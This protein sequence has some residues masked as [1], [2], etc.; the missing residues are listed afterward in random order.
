MKKRTIKNAD[1]NT[2]TKT[3]VYFVP[4]K[5]S[6]MFI[7]PDGEVVG[8]DVVEN[9]DEVIRALNTFAADEGALDG[10]KFE[11]SVN[12]SADNVSADLAQAVKT[13]LPISTQTNKESMLA[14]NNKLRF[15]LDFRKNK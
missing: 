14:Y 9:E 2:N 15:S 4:I 3:L 12:D 6:M 7:S 13:Y 8:E 1:K 10:F 5:W 11:Q